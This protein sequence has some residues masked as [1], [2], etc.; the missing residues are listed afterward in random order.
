LFFHACKAV[1]FQCLSF[2]DIYD[3]LLRRTN[4]S[5]KNGT[6]VM[7]GTFYGYD[8]ASRLATVTD[9]T[10]SATY[11]YVANS[12]LVGQI[13]FKNNGTTR[14]TTTKSYDKLNRLTSIAN[15]PSADSTVSFAYDYNNANQR[16]RVT[17]ADG[18]YW[19]YEYDSLGQVTSGRKFWSDGTLVAGQQFDYTFD[20]IGNRKQ[21]KAGGDQNG[22]GKRV[23][24]Y[25]VN[26]LN[27]YT[28][29]DV[30]GG[31]D[32]L[33]VARGT[34]TVNGNSAYRKGEY[35]RNEVSV[36]N[37]STPQYQAVNVTATDGSSVSETGTVFV[38]KTPEVFGYDLDGN[39][40]NDGRW[41]L[42]WD[43]ENRLIQM[44]SLPSAP[45][46]SS[47]RLTFTYDVQSRR[48]QKLSEVFTNSGWGT[49]F[50]NR[51]VYDEWN[52]L[53]IVDNV[54]A[55]KKSFRWGADLN[56]TMEGDGGAG[57]LLSVTE[58]FG[59]NTGVN[60]Y[61]HDGNGNVAS[62]I[63]ASTGAALAEYEYDLFHRLLRATEPLTFTNPFLAAT[64]FFDRETGFYYYGYRYYD[65]QA[66]RWPNR[67]P[68]N[69]GDVR[70]AYTFVRNRPVGETDVLGLAEAGGFIAIQVPPPNT[71]IEGRTPHTRVA[72]LTSLKKWEMKLT[73]AG[74]CPGEAFVRIENASAKVEYWWERGS[75]PAVERHELQHVKYWQ[76][77]WSAF[78][79]KA[80]SLGGVCR[81][82]LKKANCYMNAI[83]LWSDYF[84][85]DAAQNNAQY[86]NVSY[87][88]NLDPIYWV[89][90]LEQAKAA[91]EKAFNAVKN[92]EAE[93]AKECD[94]YLIL[95]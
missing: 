93:C 88:Q 72:G 58:H 56:G 82:S 66:G 1:C 14:M 12:P 20:D 33:G 51:F 49:L 2:T 32:V 75:S 73:I 44:Q 23:A 92:K 39:L 34:V 60:F 69:N 77:A 64:K 71:P 63:G 40:T 6:A 89:Q 90:Q 36:S 24:S 78:N 70:D 59:A 21:T 76:D 48:I 16:T 67:D 11:T 87:G 9:G 81:C 68:F 94:D 80:A 29:R 83:V 65:P 31:F 57:G 17:Q 5:V 84:K 55:T 13:E 10:N 62:L 15:V 41:V 28:Q 74:C 30:P 4:V 85:A 38:A 53:V 37:G 95:R 8:N 19:R 86:D 47:N 79:E 18:S 35:F 26:D 7:A 42:T 50:D 61:G 43:G 54:N 91:K 25:S 22:S 45:I 46:G 3:S 52:L 27:Q